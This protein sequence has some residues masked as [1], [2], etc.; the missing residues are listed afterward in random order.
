MKILTLKITENTVLFYTTR[1]I[2]NRSFTLREYTF[3]AFL[4]PVTLTSTR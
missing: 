2:P 4:A 1:V 3:S